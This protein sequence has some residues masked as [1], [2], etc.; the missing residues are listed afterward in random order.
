MPPELIILI[1]MIII[2]L[3]CDYTWQRLKRKWNK[4]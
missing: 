3:L 2:A 1:S 4:K